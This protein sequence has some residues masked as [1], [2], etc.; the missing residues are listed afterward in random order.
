MLWLGREPPSIYS[1]SLASSTSS[2]TDATHN[3]LLKSTY[4]P[5][6]I[7]ETN[8]LSYIFPPDQTSSDKPV[9]IDAKN[10][11]HSLS[12]RQALVWIKRLGSLLDHLSIPNGEAV[13][14]LTPNHIFVPVAYLGITGAGRIFSG[15]NPV[16]TATEVEYQIRNTGTCLILTHPSLAEV[17]IEAG[18]RAGLPK[19]RIYLFSDHEC[20]SFAGLRDWRTVPVEP[21]F[22]WDPLG[23]ASKSTLATINYSSGT[24]GLPK[25]VCV[26]HFNIVANSEQTIFMRNIETSQQDERWLGFLPL[27]HSYGKSSKA[28]IPNEK[29]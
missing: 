20:K 6:D 8:I 7:P 11:T 4:P 5:L 12:P 13:M 1:V 18:R 21:D 28:C 10:P 23:R 14:V 22:A 16:Y 17:A 9:W 27:Y 3:M 25:G 2:V 29:T 26:S 19:D 15:A 24:T